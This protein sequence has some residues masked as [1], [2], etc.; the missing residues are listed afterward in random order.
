LFSILSWR[1]GA[2]PVSAF[3]STDES[4]SDPRDP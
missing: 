4:A 2:A 1:T 3:P